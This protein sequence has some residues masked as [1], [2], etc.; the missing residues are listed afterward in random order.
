MRRTAGESGPGA[1]GVDPGP[2]SAPKAF[3]A[4]THFVASAAFFSAG[5]DLAGAVFESS[6]VATTSPIFT[7]WPSGTIVSST[8]GVS[9][10]ISVETLSVSRVKSASPAL[11]KS[12]DFLCQTETTPLEID[13]P[14]AGIFTSMAM[15]R[16]HYAQSMAAVIKQNRRRCR[17]S[18]VRQSDGFAPWQAGC[19]P[20]RG[21]GD[22]PA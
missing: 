8:P 19:D 16:L 10:V 5:S 22:T 11:T 9:A 4:A 12:P 21:A 3:G 2:R 14:T 6:M 7:S 18:R 15:T 17:G 20:K 1:G 13:S